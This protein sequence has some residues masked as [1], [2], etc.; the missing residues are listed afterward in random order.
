[1]ND[2]RKLEVWQLSKELTLEIYRITEK[3]PDAEKFGLTNQIRRC[4]VSIISNIAEGSGRNSNPDFLRFISI[5][6]GSA[7]ELDTQLEI[8]FELSFISESD[9]HSINLKLISIK[10]MLYK[11]SEY[12][13]SN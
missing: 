7:Y 6:L 4:C 11:F 12:L 5:S 1:M 9:Y 3:F 2:F 10:K 13:K 8:S